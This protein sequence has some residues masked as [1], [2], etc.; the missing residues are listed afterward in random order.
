MTEDPRK[1]AQNVIEHQAGTVI[2][3]IEAAVVAGTGIMTVEVAMIATMTEKVDMTRIKNQGDLVAMIRGVVEGHVPQGI[4]LGTT[5]DMGVVTVEMGPEV[6]TCLCPN[7]LFEL[8][9]NR[10][11]F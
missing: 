1:G 7:P 5:T 8:S 3:E 6:Y 10:W 9:G 4:V 2:E 11:E